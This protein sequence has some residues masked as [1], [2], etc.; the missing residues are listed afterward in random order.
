MG[1]G[2]QYVL[3]A[4]NDGWL[5]PKK[6]TVAGSGDDVVLVV[7]RVVGSVL[8]SLVPDDS[9]SMAFLPGSRYYGLSASIKRDQ[10]EPLLSERDLAL[11]PIAD[12]SLPPLLAP[13]DLAAVALSLAAEEDPVTIEYSVSLPGFEPADGSF[14]LE[15]VQ[16]VVPVHEI[17]LVAG[18]ERTGTL[19]VSCESAPLASRNVP[20]DTGMHG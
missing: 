3:L 14:R 10:A 18:G 1:L 15:P 6:A 5:S 19:V 7:Q 17:S 13:F 11:L 2:E 20:H 8:R 12:L 4:G 16:G 9:L